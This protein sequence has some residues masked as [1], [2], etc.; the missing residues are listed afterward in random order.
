MSVQVLQATPDA[1]CAY[2]VIIRIF[3]EMPE[4]FWIAWCNRGQTTEGD[5]WVGQFQPDMKK[6]DSDGVLSKP[7]PPREQQGH[8]L[9]I[10][11]HTGHHWLRMNE[12]QGDWRITMELG[13]R[14]PV[15]SYIVRIFERSS[16]YGGTYLSGKLE[17]HRAMPRG[18][19]PTAE[20]MQIVQQVADGT[21]QPVQVD[22]QTV[23]PVGSQTALLEKLAELQ[24]QVA[25]QNRDSV[26]PLFHE[27]QKA[28]PPS[29]PDASIPF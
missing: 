15:G 13:E 21:G 23:T 24:A 14:L 19:V 28:D 11:G 26:N 5:G 12:Y 4:A 7:R 3:K 20:T 2:W 22:Q 6:T 9:E 10:P 25:K 16:N 17:P 8:E 27:Q 1:G 29:H 18:P